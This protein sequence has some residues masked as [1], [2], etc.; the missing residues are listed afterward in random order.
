MNPSEMQQMLE[1]AQNMQ[2]QLQQ[3]MKSTVVE[4]SVGGGAVTVK[5]NG[6]K[7]VLAVK[8]DADLV[9]AGDV[10]M[11]Q[12]LVAAAVN[13]ANRKAEGELKG[14]LGGLLGGMGLPGLF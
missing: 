11:L 2:T 14:S 8:I 9:K 4:A 5:V 3:K 1:R 10:E 6:E 7:S 12:D 13:E